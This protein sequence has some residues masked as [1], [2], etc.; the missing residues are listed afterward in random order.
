MWFIPL[1]QNAEPYKNKEPVQNCRQVISS[2]LVCL[3]DCFN[4][5]DFRTH[6]WNHLVIHFSTIQGCSSRLVINQPTIFFHNYNQLPEFLRFARQLCLTSLP[7][8]FQ[9]N[10]FFFPCNTTPLWDKLST[11]HTIIKHQPIE[12]TWGLIIIAYLE[13]FLS[14]QQARLILHTAN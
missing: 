7:V 5:H 6:R 12:L 10:S 13:V 11:S 3:L 1:L 9:S 14:C 2:A 8:G 4:P